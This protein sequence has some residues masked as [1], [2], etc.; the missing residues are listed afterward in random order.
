MH[1]LRRALED[2]SR[3]V[4]GLRMDLRASLAP[5]HKSKPFYTVRELATELGRSPYTIRRWIREGKIDA[6]KLNSGGPRDRYLIDYSQ[7]Q[8]MLMNA[9]A[10]EK[11]AVNR[12][13]SESLRTSCPETDADSAGASPASDGP[14]N[15]Q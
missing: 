6:L 9:S 12:E 8:E 2:L 4:A 1:M 14:C 10:S 7:V 3:E 15:D 5:K 11:L 13:V